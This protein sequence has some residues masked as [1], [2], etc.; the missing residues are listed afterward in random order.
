MLALSFLHFL[1]EA[2]WLE[3]AHVSSLKEVIGPVSKLLN[4][5]FVAF[6]GVVGNALLSNRPLAP[7]SLVAI[8]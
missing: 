2:N 3:N 6:L 1:L 7:C 8:L 4:H 5:S